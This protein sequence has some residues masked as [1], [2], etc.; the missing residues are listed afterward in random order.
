[1]KTGKWQNWHRN[2]KFRKKW[3]NEKIKTKRNIYR[4]Y[5][6]VHGILQRSVTKVINELMKQPLQ[7][8]RNDIPKFGWLPTRLLSILLYIIL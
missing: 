2:N 4:E 8:G 7:E 1:M 5:N 3:H 6:I